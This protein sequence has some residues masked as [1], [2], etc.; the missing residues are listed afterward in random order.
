MATDEKEQIQGSDK[1][2]T[3]NETAAPV[4]KNYKSSGI[5]LWHYVLIFFCAGAVVLLTN[6][7][8]SEPQNIEDRVSKILAQTPLIGIVSRRCRHQTDCA[9]GHND[10]P[11][12]IRDAFGN[13]IYDKEFTKPFEKGS[14]AGQVDLPRLAKGKVGGTFWSVFVPCPKDGG[15]LSNEGYAESM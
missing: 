8:G 5:R 15:D 9:D 3:A 1:S 11:Y 13:R 4:A 14:F 6:I 12:L 2:K 7:R 10:L